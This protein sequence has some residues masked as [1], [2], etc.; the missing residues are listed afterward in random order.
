MITFGAN[1][2]YNQM[3]NAIGRD[4]IVTC[5]NCHEDF[6]TKFTNPVYIFVDEYHPDTLAELAEDVAKGL[7][8]RLFCSYPC[9]FETKKKLNFLFNG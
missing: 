6:N 4:S 8:G 5:Q 1:T 3:L 9:A 2:V 7:K